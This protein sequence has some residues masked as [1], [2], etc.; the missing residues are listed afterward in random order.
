MENADLA[1]LAVQE[2][3]IFLLLAAQRTNNRKEYL[4]AT[5]CDIT[6]WRAAALSPAL[7]SHNVQLPLLSSH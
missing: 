5:Y 4:E 3:D 7:L 1:L 6:D 2:M